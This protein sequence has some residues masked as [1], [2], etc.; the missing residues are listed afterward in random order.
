MI[1]IEQLTQAE[2]QIQSLLTQNESNWKTIAKIAIVVQQQKLFKQAELNSFT[3]WVNA[4]AKKCERQPSLIWRY[5]KAAKYYLKSV[6]S[7]D[8]EQVDEAKAPPEALE[9]LEKVERNAPQPVFEKLR[10]KV[11]AGEATVKE[12]RKIEQEYRPEGE[13]LRRG[14]PPKGQEGT[15]QHLGSGEA[16][17]LTT[18]VIDVTAIE[19]E[20]LPRNQVAV[21]I[22]RSLTNS[23]VDWTMQCS[24]MKYPPYHH[25]EHTEVRVSVDKKRL[26]LDFLAVV[27]W[28]YKRPKDVFGVEI[29][30]CLAD[31]EADN[32]W[33]N[34]LNFCH[35]FCFAIP[36]S[37]EELRET[38]ET[39]TDA[40]ILLVD[41]TSEIEENLSYP[42]AV[43]RS[44]QSRSGSSVSLVYET[45]YERILGWSGSD[46]QL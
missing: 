43:Y 33:E 26:R 37:D 34:Y 3:A 30:S 13:Q 1:S 23:L 17:A 9:K 14:R 20:Q 15:Y 12:C 22:A 38:I 16:S 18:Q 40:G 25:Q 36:Q 2:Q 35:Y 29:K 46:N 42:V 31:F 8:I 32:K 10:E 7:D 5:I 45:L 19:V 27:R 41:F 21:T 4:V 6:D 28:S 44:P 39:Q 24:G 11:L